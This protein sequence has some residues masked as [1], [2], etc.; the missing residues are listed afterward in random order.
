M[1]NMIGQSVRPWGRR[2]TGHR[3]IR[4]CFTALLTLL[5]EIVMVIRFG[6]LALILL[7]CTPARS[8]TGNGLLQACEALEREALIEGDSIQLPARTDVHECW[9]Y[10]GAAQ[11]FSAMV[12]NQTGKRLL[13]SCLGPKTTLTQ[14]IR[15][16]TNYARTHPQELHEKAS[17]LVYR[18]MLNAFPCP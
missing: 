10:M 16:F 8:E 9:G 18:A 3:C 11:D 2:W 15:V 17:L 6:L 5:A 1:N 14:L 4:R 12:N 13:N 7:L